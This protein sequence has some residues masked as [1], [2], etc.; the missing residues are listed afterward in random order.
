MVAWA[1]VTANGDF[2]DSILLLYKMAVSFQMVTVV[3]SIWIFEDLAKCMAVLVV[4]ALPATA[5]AAGRL[6]VMFIAQ[7]ATVRVRANP[8]SCR[9]ERQPL[10]LVVGRGE[11]LLVEAARC[12]CWDA[13]VCI[14]ATTGVVAVDNVVDVVR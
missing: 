14:S 12:C 9:K 4:L 2:D 6:A 10:Q 13:M 3:G 7:G 5:A 1:I 11:E 8:T